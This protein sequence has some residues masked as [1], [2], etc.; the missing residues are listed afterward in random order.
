M[1]I[2]RFSKEPPPEKYI[3]FR[4]EWDYDRLRKKPDK[5]LYN[6]AREPTKREKK[7]QRKN[8]AF[9]YGSFAATGGLSGI[10][11]KNGIKGAAVGSVLGLTGAGVIDAYGRAHHAK[12]KR[13]AKEELERRGK[14]F[15]AIENIRTGAIL[16]A[17]LPTL[18]TNS[19]G[20]ANLIGAGVGALLL[21]GMNLWMNYEA[22]K[23]L[24][25][26]KKLSEPL[27]LEDLL[28]KYPKL[29]QASIFFNP[30][31]NDQLSK[32]SMDLDNNRLISDWEITCPFLDELEPRGLSNSMILIHGDSLFFDTK[33]QDFYF[34][35]GGKPRKITIP[36]YKE[37]LI[38]S[39]ELAIENAN[40]ND[41]KRTGEKILKELK[42]IIK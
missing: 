14:T 7:N 11:A 36:E 3:G 10:A 23:Y 42:S 1:R 18:F 21:G 34:D 5:F 37:Y 16:G 20:K 19:F 40:T 15:S 8:R 17:C 39:I 28:K 41:R 9:L 27:N 6:T 13:I 30:R 33:T 35:G 29:N 12:R 2:K 26:T 25:T 31:V 38:N 32:I 24:S 4:E 22:N